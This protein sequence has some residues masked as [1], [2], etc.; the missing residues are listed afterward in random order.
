VVG[1]QVANM[2]MFMELSSFSSFALPPTLSW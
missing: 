2:I 1:G